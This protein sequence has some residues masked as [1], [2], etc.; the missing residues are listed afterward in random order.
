MKYLG[1]LLFALCL[2]ICAKAQER[3]LKAFGLGVEIPIPTQS[4]YS[5]GIGASGKLEIPLT[6]NLG[7]TVTSGITEMYY[8]SG[9][10]YALD[11]P[12]TDTFVPLKGGLRYFLGPGVYAEGEMGNTFEIEHDKRDLFTYAIG[13]GFVAPI[14]GGKNGIDVSFR[15]E[16]WSNHELRLTAFRVAY[17]FGW[18]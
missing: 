4:V 2:T 16:S 1:L 8:K 14:N 11:V 10:V 12:S 15:Y 3:D 9:L 7:L 17:R 6:G 18:R 13:P 5:I